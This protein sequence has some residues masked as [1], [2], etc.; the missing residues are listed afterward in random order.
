MSRNVYA[1]TLPSGK[2]KWTYNRPPKDVAWKMVGKV[3]DNLSFESEPGIS[4]EEEP[5][6]KPGTHQTW[7]SVIK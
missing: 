2:I 6:G 1:I 4:L 3:H 7:L 5:H